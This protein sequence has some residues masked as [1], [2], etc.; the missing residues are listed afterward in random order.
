MTEKEKKTIWRIAIVSL[1]ATLTTLLAIYIRE[2]SANWLVVWVFMYYFILL[3]LAE[4][5]AEHNKKRFWGVLILSAIIATIT[6]FLWS[7]TPGVLTSITMTIIGFPILMVLA[8]F[9]SALYKGLKNL[10]KYLKKRKQIKENKK[11]WKKL[12]DGEIEPTDHEEFIMKAVDWW[13]RELSHTIKQETGDAVCNGFFDIMSENCKALTKEQVYAFGVD[14]AHAI[15]KTE[16]DHCS[17]RTDWHPCGVLYDLARKRRIR[18]INFP[19]RME[20]DINFKNETISIRHLDEPI[21]TEIWTPHKPSNREAA[22][23]CGF[24]S[25]SNIHS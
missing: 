19:L 13:K 7:D 5:I 8:S 25:I 17:L 21:W 16:G 9:I 11:R 23:P 6:T 15:S 12:F 1:I 14:L 20:M 22:I 24:F 10:Q 18:H 4:W 3:S 2:K